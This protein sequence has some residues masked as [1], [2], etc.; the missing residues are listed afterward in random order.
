MFGRHSVEALAHTLV[1]DATMMGDFSVCI[2]LTYQRGDG[3]A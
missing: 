2:L 1:Y 3:R